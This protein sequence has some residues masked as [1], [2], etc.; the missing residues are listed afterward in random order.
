MEN[1][2]FQIDDLHTRINQNRLTPSL[3]AQ[4]KEY[5]RIGLT[6]TSNALEGNTLTESETKVVLEEGITIGGKRLIEHLEAIGHSDA[7][8]HLY[9]L[10]KANDI[11]LDD[12]NR[13]HYL[14]YY[15]IDQE[16]AGRYR[17]VKA[18][19]TGSQYPLPL[20]TLL[21]DLMDEL[22]NQ[23]GKW[24]KEYH[25]VHVA[26]LLHKE[27]V[28]IHPYIDGNG[29]VARLLM[30]LFLLQEGYEIALIPPIM[31]SEY[32]RALEKAHK[33]DSDFLLFIA[34][35]V[36]EAQQDYLRLFI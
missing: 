15:R 14:F 21:Q 22:P 33:D 19:I 24:R 35:M 34:N 4:I 28:F 16:N 10:I 23:L 13:L 17:K 11:T 1:I 25:P 3:L 7:Y 5:Y 31:R 26:A 12:I 32:F 36:R 2:F 6:Y 9:E 20:P 30:N 27:F 8:T 29:R 18:Y